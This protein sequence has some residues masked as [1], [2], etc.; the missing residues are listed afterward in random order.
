MMLHAADLLNRVLRDP[1]M[2]YR[3]FSQK[4][5]RHSY[6]WVGTQRPH[7]VHPWEWEAADDGA[8]VPERV[9]VWYLRIIKLMQSA[10]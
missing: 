4:L 10:D 1:R 3:T 7:V 9:V 8:F 6:R 2:T 5:A